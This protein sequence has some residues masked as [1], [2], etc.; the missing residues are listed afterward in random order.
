MGYHLAPQRIMA[1][2][3]KIFGTDGIRGL[4]N[5]H[6]MTSEMSL[7]LGRAIAYVFQNGGKRHGI[8]IGKDTRISGYMLETALASGI[9]SMGAD[10]MLVGPL[11]TPAVA[12]IT[13]GMRAD[14]GVVISASHNAYEDNGIKFFDRNGFKLPDELESQMESLITTGEVDHHRP[15]KDGIGKAIRIDDANG[16]YIE[17]LK[18]TVPKGMNFNGLKVVLDCAHGSGY[19]VAPAVLT[20]LG[21][22]VIAIGVTPDGKNI[23][24]GCGSTHPELMARLVKE[25]NAD[26]GIALDGDADRIIMAD[27]MGSIV[28][29]DHILSI[30]AQHMH[31]H[32]EL[33]KGTLVTTVM[34]NLGI[35]K[36]MHA[37]G[38]KVVRTSVGDR[39]VIQAMRTS[40][41]NLGGEQSGHII[42]SDH[43][44]T[45]DGTM[46][47]LQVLSVLLERD[48]PLSM[49]KKVF[50]AFPQ[51]LTNVRVREKKEFSQIPELSKQIK[52]VERE[53]GQNGRL[54]IRYSG[55]E[56]LARIMIEG[57]NKDRLSNMAN[58]LADGINKHLG[59]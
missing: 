44:T 58:D 19:K 10:V 12:F 7:Q 43:G 28:D 29:G 36:A 51:V 52:E 2:I 30:C 38:I 46:A 18:R 26:L 54:V 9:C 13:Q 22:K 23:N 17:F 1:D 20:E 59:R 50:T 21:A 11:P 40:G 57:E 24:S 48:Q 39:Y 5:I 37:M 8:V 32:G 53:L 42:F 16:R 33:V 35:D 47:G 56:M 31:K 34:G 25:H 41:Y 6:P 55:T 45:G 27:E 49:V 3:R 4:A 15:T 14:A